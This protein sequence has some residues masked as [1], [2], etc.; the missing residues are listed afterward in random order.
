MLTNIGLPG[1]LLIVSVFS[2]SGLNPV[3]P[4]G[5]ALFMAHTASLGMAQ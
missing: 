3:G 4:G 5:F 1:L 2:S